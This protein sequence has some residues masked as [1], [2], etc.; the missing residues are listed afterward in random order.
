MADSKSSQ[1]EVIEAQLTPDDLGNLAEGWDGVEIEGES[2][3]VRLKTD[4]I[5]DSARMEVV[6]EAYHHTYNHAKRELRD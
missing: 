2:V 3:I 5:H 4:D 6:Q 1:K